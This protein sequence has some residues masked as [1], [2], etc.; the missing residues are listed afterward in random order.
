MAPRHGPSF[1][2]RSVTYTGVY[3]SKRAILGWRAQF[4]HSGKVSQGLGAPWAERP[5]ARLQRGREARPSCMF[6]LAMSSPPCY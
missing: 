1:A 3:Q 2:S 5:A 4:C 6:L